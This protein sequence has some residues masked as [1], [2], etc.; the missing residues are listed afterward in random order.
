M[1][2]RAKLRTFTCIAIISLS[3][4]AVWGQDITST[5]E[6]GKSGAI[7]KK[8]ASNSAPTGAAALAAPVT[9]TFEGFF[10]FPAEIRNFIPMDGGSTAYFRDVFAAGETFSDGTPND[11]D[12]LGADIISP[13]GV[14]SSFSPL[15]FHT[16]FNGQQNCWV[17]FNQA[18]CDAA[19]IDVLW[20]SSIQCGEDGTWTMDFSYN[21]AKFFTGTFTVLPQ[22]KEDAIT[23]VY[24]QGAFKTPGLDEYDS[25]CR[26]VVNGVPLHESHICNSSKSLP[27]EIPWFI[28]GK[29]CFLS[30]AAMVF[31]YFDAPIDPRG[32]NSFLKS[33]PSGYSSGLVNGSVAIQSPAGQGV[34]IKYRGFADPST[35]SQAVCSAGPQLMGVKCKP[36]NQGVL[37]ATHWVLAF[38]RDKDKTTWLLKDPA[39]G[40]STTLAAKYGNNFCEVRTF[41]GPEFTF[42]DMTGLTV[43]FHSPG[44]LLITDPSGRRLGADLLTNASFQEIPNSAYNNEPLEDDDTGVPDD[45][46]DTMKDIEV[47]SPATGDYTLTITG[48]GNGTYDMEIQG[49]DANGQPSLSTFSGVPIS[50]N[51]VQTIVIHY[52]SA[53][54]TQL[55]LSG[56]FDGGGQRPKD[57]N[58]FLSYGNPTSN[59]VSLA[60][61]RASFPL[62]IFY[63]D[64]VLPSTFSATLGGT[65]VTQLFH[66]VA[67]GHEFVSLPMVSGRNVLDLSIQGNLPSRTATDSDRLVFLVP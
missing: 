30:D 25:L 38:G 10:R 61:G 27:G 37:K 5:H 16:T 49:L 29:G 12:T 65:D 28:S 14:I 35:L 40:V 39:G 32:L 43:S 6:P 55:Q 34:N 47:V 8:R 36:N 17:G 33:K 22:V 44:E 46:S 2:V 1:T 3:C 48:T 52:D 4:L 13:S 15:T 56:G 54:G 45:D 66:P 62:L 31:G 24:N 26:N 7:V 63:S 23:N 64:T 59:H 18:L 58:H 57:V 51:Q 67:G 50:T 21:G 9:N 53:P 11:G 42:T 60:A 20:F 41:Q 19:S